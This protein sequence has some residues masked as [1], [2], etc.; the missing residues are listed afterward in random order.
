M[1]VRKF[2]PLRIPTTNVAR[3][4]RFYREV[5]DLP[6]EFGENE[7]RHLY[8]DQQSIVFEEDPEADPI[9]VQ[10][11]VRDHKETV[12]NHFIN[13][14]VTQA[15]PATESED[16]RHIIFHLDDFEGNHIEVIANK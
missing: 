8:F 12:E 1:R 4:V 5:F 2:A 16:D 10:V 3:A 13:Y 9:V 15:K 14:Y 6:T 7:S 11:T